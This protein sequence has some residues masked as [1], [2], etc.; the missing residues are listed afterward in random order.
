MRKDLI[1]TAGRPTRW[2]NQAPW[3]SNRLMRPSDRSGPPWSSPQSQSGLLRYLSQQQ[4]AR[5]STRPAERESNS[6]STSTAN[7]VAR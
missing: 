5:P 6:N 3:S 7:G 1:H 2:W 4:S